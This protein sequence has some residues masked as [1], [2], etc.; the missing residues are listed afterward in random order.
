MQRESLAWAKVCSKDAPRSAGTNFL[1]ISLL[2]FPRR[3]LH[4]KAG[5]RSYALPQKRQSTSALHKSCTS[6]HVGWLRWR[7]TYQNRLCGQEHGM[8]QLA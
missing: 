5:S 8:C 2:S 1:S 6:F 4:P 3:C 7:P